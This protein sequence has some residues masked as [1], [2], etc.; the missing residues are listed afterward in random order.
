MLRQHELE[1]G[2]RDMIEDRWKEP[3]ELRRKRPEEP[4][5]YE[6]RV[7]GPMRFI[8][9]GFFLFWWL[10][11]FYMTF[12]TRKDGLAAHIFVY[13][14]FAFGTFM[15]IRVFSSLLRSRI[16]VK[17]ETIT[18]TTPLGKTKTWHMEDITRVTVSRQRGGTEFRAYIGKRR[19]FSVHTAM[20]NCD[21]LLLELQHRG[22][23]FE[24]RLF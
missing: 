11:L 22:V 20:T 9:G 24:R 1:G 3:E 2:T 14:F 6:L 7:N 4:R 16:T 15:V 5:G 18:E 12:F 19:A 10:L 13:V 8:G 21:R 17:G 23:P